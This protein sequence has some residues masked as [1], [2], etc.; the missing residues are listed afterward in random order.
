M[1]K[2]LCFLV[3][4]LTVLLLQNIFTEP[5]VSAPEQVLS[6]S[7]YERTYDRT[8]KYLLKQ[9]DD[10]VLVSEVANAVL[11][12]AAKTGIAPGLIVSI[13]SYE[14]PGLDTLAISYAGAIGLMQIMPLH[15]PELAVPCGVQNTEDLFKVQENICAGVYILS[16]KMERCNDSPK[17]ALLAYNGC[18]VRNEMPFRACYTYPTRVENHLLDFLGES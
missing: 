4:V 1:S 13:M 18:V 6:V 7:G 10:P 9:N 5:F 16:R 11:E 17:C 14:S 15:V 12:N 2:I 8:I 3:G